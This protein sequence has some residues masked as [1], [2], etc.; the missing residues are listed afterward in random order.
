MEKRILGFLLSA[1]IIA[2]LCGCTSESNT[3]NAEPPSEIEQFEESG[4]LINNWTVPDDGGETHPDATQV[5]EILTREI[6]DKGGVP[7]PNAPGETLELFKVKF[8]EVINTDDMCTMICDISY[9]G[10]G[11]LLE[12]KNSY[13]KF[14]KVGTNDAIGQ[15]EFL[16][17]EDISG[18]GV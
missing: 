3:E 6:N 11:Y 15:W 7:N 2:A 1:I 18:R 14:Q 9:Q 8:K 12:Y 13:L 17:I 16:E 4:I 5:K 10:N